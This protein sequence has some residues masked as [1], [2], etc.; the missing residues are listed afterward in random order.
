MGGGTT[1]VPNISLYY[2]ANRE[3]VEGRRLLGIATVM[4]M[5]VLRIKVPV[6]MGDAWGSKK[7]SQ[8]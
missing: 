2:S 3:H 8:L 1:R 4:V 5:A 7:I 6:L